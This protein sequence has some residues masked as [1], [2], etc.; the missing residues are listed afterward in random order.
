M[1]KLRGCVSCILGMPVEFNN[2]G[3]P[4][5]FNN[6]TESIRDESN[7]LTQ[8]IRDML[9]FVRTCYE[10]T[11]EVFHVNEWLC[12]A[13]ERNVRK[14]HIRV[15]V[16]EIDIGW[17]VAR[18]PQCILTCNTLVEL[19][20]LSDFVF[21][22]PD[23]TMCFPSL[24]LL[25]INLRNPD[26]DLLQKLFCSCPVLEDLSIF[27]DLVAAPLTFDIMV[28][29]LKML[30]IWLYLDL[31]YFEGVSQKKDCSDIEDSDLSRVSSWICFAIDHG[32][33]NLT[34]KVDIVEAW[35]GWPFDLPQS[36]LTCKTLV[37]LRLESLH[38]DFFLDI[39][40]SMCFPSLKILHITIAFPDASLMQKLFSSCP[41]LEDLSIHAS[42]LYLGYLLM[43]DICVPTLKRLN[44]RHDVDFSDFEGISEHKYVITARNLEYLCIQDGSLT[45]VVVN[46]RP[47][48]N[49][50]NLNVG[51]YSLLID[52]LEFEVSRDEANRVMELLRGINLTKILSLASCSMDALGLAFDDDMPTFPN[53][54][55]LELNIEAR[56]GWKLLPYFLESSPNLEVLILEMDYL[57]TEYIPGDFVNFESKNVPSCLKL[58]VKTIE[59]K[60]MMGEE[61]ELEVVSYM[62]RNCEVLKEF[63]AHISDK[64]ESK[65]DL[66]REI[67]ICIV[68]DENE[69]SDV[70]QWLCF[71]IKLKVRK[72]NIRV[73]DVL[74]MLVVRL[75]QSIL[76]C[77]TLVELCM[78]CDFVFDIPDSSTCFP[79]LKLLHI[80]LIN[81]DYDLLKKLFRSCPVLED[82]SIHWDCVENPL[83]FDIIMPT[84]K[85]LTICLYLD[86]GHFVGVSLLKFVLT[87]CNLEYLIIEDDALVNFVVKGRPLVN[88][89]SL[90]VGVAYYYKF[91]VSHDE[92]NRV[93]KLLRGVNYTKILSLTSITMNSLNLG[94]DDDMP[95]FPNLIRL[96]ICIEA[97]FGW[98]LLPHFLN[99]S[100]NLE[101][102]ILKMDYDQE[103]SL[104][105][106]VE[107]ELE[108]VPSCLRLHVKTIEI[109]NMTRDE[110][111]LDVISYML[112]NSKV[113][114]E[115]SVG[116]ANAE[117]KRILWRL[118]LLYPTGSVACEVNFL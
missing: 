45:S 102:L 26:Y 59:I 80:N 10:S 41:V 52:D 47:L 16:I 20:M 71:A 78:L 85:R 62:L 110:D 100:S 63:N 61:D 115:F 24:K 46:E 83:T 93:M 6:L 116:I 21:D 64:A 11:R 113:L 30:T 38:N 101:V 74:G 49:E 70:S 81:P 111:E 32:V 1:M 37:K 90:D 34:I 57:L 87:A 19:Y 3:M 75:P 92:A 109:R 91:E 31:L 73:N 9:M 8:S 2:S 66:W 97:R 106:F 15:D 58:H 77:N 114:E 40:D 12:F 53:L 67:L 89:V 7:N 50:V 4:V 104:E 39:P 35:H 86:S 99:S 105:E 103:Y 95:T 96:E 54:I 72:L 56:F 76:T 14:L 5:E 60:N 65:E 98:K 118:I 68:D 36:I 69:L 23:S 88:E 13:V 33:R 51:V 55:R 43:F 44:I 29:T 94:F 79:S 82:L 84:L 117:L 27:G 18:L 22:I 42:Y 28:P 108:S 112:K 107:F 48:L 17:W 25:F